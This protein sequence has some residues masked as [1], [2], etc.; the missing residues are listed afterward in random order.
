MSA[1]HATPSRTLSASPSWRQNGYG[2]VSPTIPDRVASA[3]DTSEPGSRTGSDFNRASLTRLKTAV[4]MAIPSPIDSTATA[5]NAGERRMSRRPDLTSAEVSSSSRTPRASRPASFQ[6][7]GSPNA[8]RARRSASGR[9]TPFA[10][11]SS[12]R[13]AR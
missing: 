7:V 2:N 12:M 9:G 10:T 6:R 8:A 4:L 5:A 1:T 11:R 3:N 13:N